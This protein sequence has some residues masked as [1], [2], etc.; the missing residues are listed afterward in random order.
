MHIVEYIR[1][2]IKWLKKIWDFVIWAKW[3]VFFQVSI[4]VVL[5][6]SRL[7][8]LGLNASDPSMVQLLIHGA[9]MKSLYIIYIYLF[10]L[11][12]WELVRQF[13]ISDVI[14]LHIYCGKFSYSCVVVCQT[15]ILH[16]VWKLTYQLTWEVYLKTIF[17]NVVLEHLGKSKVVFKNFIYSFCIIWKLM[18]LMIYKGVELL[19]S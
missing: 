16:L 6:H 11:Q 8:W 19:C 17:Q 12:T 15:Q 5:K 10:P 9:K 13:S 1:D 14:P 18:N 2:L 3:I 7:K 4:L